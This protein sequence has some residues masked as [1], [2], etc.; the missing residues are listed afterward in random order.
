LPTQTRLNSIDNSS[1]KSTGPKSRPEGSDRIDI[2][3][4]R[5]R[6]RKDSLSETAANRDALPLSAV[7]RAHE[8]ASVD[9]IEE[10]GRGAGLRLCKRSRMEK[11]PRPVSNRAAASVA[12][13][14]AI[15]GSIRSCS[16]A[17]L[18]GTDGQAMFYTGQQTLRVTRVRRYENRCWRGE[19]CP[20]APRFRSALP[21]QYHRSQT[22]RSPPWWY[23]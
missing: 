17:T 6:L 10:N 22:T 16:T 12:C 9:F 4:G 11:E 7:Q 1:A 3:G 13:R 20:A 5:M 2:G 8:A 23:H 19:E 18:V 21:S 15:C 14:S